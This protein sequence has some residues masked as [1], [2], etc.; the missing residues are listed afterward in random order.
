MCTRLE[1]D[2]DNDFLKEN[3]VIER[4]SEKLVYFVNEREY[5]Q[6]GKSDKVRNQTL[7]VYKFKMILLL[8]TQVTE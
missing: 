4:K 5:L 7:M 6:N 8:K 2:L 1:A 3:Q